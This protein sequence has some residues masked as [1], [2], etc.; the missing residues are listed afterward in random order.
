MWYRMSVRCV[1]QVFSGLVALALM[2]DRLGGAGE[3]RL[4]LL[5]ISFL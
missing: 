3:G 5:S 4:R 2:L 1:K